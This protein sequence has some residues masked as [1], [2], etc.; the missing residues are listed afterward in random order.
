MDRTNSPQWISHRG[1]YKHQVENTLGA[2]DE[3]VNLGFD[4][5]ETDLRITKDGHL[6]LCH[7]TNL[8]RL[9]GP[10][11]DIWTLTRNELQKSHLKYYSKVLFFEQFADRYATSD[12]VIDIKPEEGEKTIR[13]LKDW[14]DYNKAHKLLT[15]QAWFLL[16][17]KSHEQMILD[18]LPNAV[19][20]ASEQ[21]C[22]RSGISLYL[23]LSF[24]GG[25][26]KNTTYSLPAKLWHR[27]LFTKKIV[28]KIHNYKA[29]ALA[30]LPETEEETNQAIKAGFD[31]ILT[32]LPPIKR[33][34][35]NFAPKKPFRKK[36]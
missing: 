32:E 1:Y 34:F 25:F 14:T 16:W 7:D 33:R 35:S 10:K 2:F 19:I 8:E 12:W 6:V 28:Q 30:F 17:N 31:Y 4:R 24:L 5:L 27:N 3:A 21:K 15:N 23:G 13:A 26:K 18:F 29:K 11:E 36:R 20:L 22:W 9:G